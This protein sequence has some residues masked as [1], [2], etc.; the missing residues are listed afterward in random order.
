MLYIHVCYM[1]CKN[2]D[3]NKTCFLLYSVKTEHIDF[4][5]YKMQI[6]CYFCSDLCKPKLWKSMCSVD[7]NSHF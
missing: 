4:P 6:M 5:K 7:W 1:Y 3:K 2:G